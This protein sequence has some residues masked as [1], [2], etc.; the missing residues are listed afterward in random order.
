MHWDCYAEYRTIAAI[1]DYYYTNVSNTV[2]MKNLTAVINNIVFKKE[3]SAEFLLFALKYAVDH[4]IPIRAPYGLYYLI[5]NTRVKGEWKT[6]K[7]DAQ[8]AKLQKAAEAANEKEGPVKN[9]FA[10]RPDMRKGFGKILK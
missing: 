8:R 2:V 10:H 7:E 1:R 5:D 4:K 6:R 3:V 9:T